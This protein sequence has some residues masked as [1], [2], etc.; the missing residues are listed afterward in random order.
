MAVNCGLGNPVPDKPIKKAEW[1]RATETR[2]QALA[3]NRAVALNA[4]AAM[5]EAVDPIV[6][7]QRAASRNAQKYWE[8][9]VFETG[10][11]NFL[12]PQ[13]SDRITGWLAN[14]IG[15]KVGLAKQVREPILNMKR[16]SDGLVREA[17]VYSMISK[18]RDLSSTLKSI[19]KSRGAKIG[20][21][22][23]RERV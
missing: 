5:Y 3:E 19:A 15:S 11:I 23:C 13:A 1:N 21:A 6:R 2:L 22:S 7:R 18:Q 16:I 8:K 17:G 4:Q 14:W 20:R 9:M 10:H 12:N